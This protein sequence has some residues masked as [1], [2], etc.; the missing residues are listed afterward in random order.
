MPQF[1]SATELLSPGETALVIV[2]DGKNLTDNHDGTGSTGWW[3]IDPQRKVDRVIIY[4]RAS[5][6]E[7]DND[8]FTATH[9]GVDGP[10]EDGRYLIRLL[11]LT[12]AGHSDSNWRDFA[13]TRQNP[14]RYVSK[15]SM[16]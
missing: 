1:A 7:T 2:T 3:V 8:L 9:D 15:P 11:G 6:D 12:L 16:A 5:A 10:R 4:R 14:I 13:A